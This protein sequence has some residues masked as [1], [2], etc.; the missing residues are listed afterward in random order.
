MYSDAEAR[1][2]KVLEDPARQ[3]EWDRFHKLKEDSRVTGIGRLLR[4]TS[5][6]E[7]PQLL[8]VLW[9][10]MSLVGP[11]PL[12]EYHYEKM[13][14]PFRS[15]YLDV[16]PG[17]TGLWQV[18]GR[19]DEDLGRMTTLNSWYARN[20]SLWLDLTILLRTVPAVLFRRGAY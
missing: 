20:W 17:I 1:L 2:A 14:E 9:G 19:S 8:N 6:D 4:A 10:T 12:P 18:S 15:D 13:G 11:R 5:L 7:L 16:K 3:D